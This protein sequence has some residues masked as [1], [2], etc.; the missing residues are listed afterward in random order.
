M[1]KQG[2]GADRDALTVRHHRRGRQRRRPGGRDAG[3]QRRAGA[4]LAD[5]DRGADQG[6]DAR[7]Q[8]DADH[9]RAR[10][11]RRQAPHRPRHKPPLQLDGLLA[12]GGGCADPHRPEDHGRRAPTA[13]A[14]GISV[15][16][17]IATAKN[18]PGRD[19]LVLHAGM[20]SPGGTGFDI[21]GYVS[22]ITPETAARVHRLTLQGVP[23]DHRRGRQRHDRHRRRRRRR[24]CC[25]PRAAR[26]STTFSARRSR[27]LLA[28]S[29]LST[30]D[31]ARLDQHLTAIRDIEVKITTTTLTIPDAAVTRMKTIDP[32]PYDQSTRD[33]GRQAVHGADGVLGR[34]RLQPRGRAE[35]RRSHRRSRVHVQRP[36]G[37]VSRRIAPA[38]HERARLPSLPRSHDARVTTSTCSTRCRRTTPRPGR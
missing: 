5:G 14:M 12:F 13:K 19:P 24:R 32:K 2:V 27:T 30:S 31:R 38:G 16:T 18:P 4:V 34:G 37:Q 36:V 1:S 10:R 15:D 3:R 33:D 25:G 6:Q 8:G 26:A 23:S 17:A 28:R 7:G 20:F 9:R 11:L 22:Y 29:D 21:P 35:D